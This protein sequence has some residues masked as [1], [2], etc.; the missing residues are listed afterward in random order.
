MTA[1]VFDPQSISGGSIAEDGT[2]LIVNEPI[3]VSIKK[4]D[5]NGNALSGAVLQIVKLEDG[6]DEEIVT[7]WSSRNDAMV[8]S[9]GL[10][11]GVRYILREQGSLTGYKTAADVAFKL[12]AD[13]TIDPDPDKTTA[14][15]K[16][17]VILFRN[18]PTSVSIKRVDS[19]GAVL[20]GAVLQILDKNNN[21]V[22]EWTSADDAAVIT[23]ILVVEES[24]TLHEKTPIAAYKKADD[25]TIQLDWNGAI[26]TAVE[27]DSD[28]VILFRNQPAY[29]VQVISR[30][31]M[32]KTNESGAAEQTVAKGTAITDVV[33]TAD[34]G[35]YFP[36]DYTVETVNGISVTRKNDSQIIVSGK[37]TNN[38]VITLKNPTRVQ[39]IIKEPQG[40]EY[41]KY[42]ENV[43]QK[44]LKEPGE[45]EN[46][47]ILYRVRVKGD[48][49]FS[50]EVP[51]RI[52]PGSYTVEWYV[53]G[54]ENY[55]DLG[56]P[57][58]PHGSI[59]V[60]ITEMED[61]IADIY[62]V[63]RNGSH[64]IPYGVKD[65]TLSFTIRVMN[66]DQMVAEAKNVSLKVSSGDSKVEIPVVFNGKVTGQ[67]YTVSLVGL[68]AEVRGGVPG[69][70]GPAFRLS[71]KAWITDKVTIYLTWDDGQ[72][73]SEP[74]KLRI[75]AL[76]EDEIGAYRLL[77]DG[78]KEYLIF[79]TYDI[80][81]AW[82]GSDELCSGYEHC[83]HKS[84]PY[85]NPFAKGGYIGEIIV[86]SN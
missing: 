40:P 49:E 5:E 31:N 38:A 11:A 74:Q 61:V 21:V 48:E 24:Y 42:S 71:Y 19:D 8:I 47:T 81:M 50:T 85:E 79:N 30:S 53:K 65:L 37:P 80:C 12:K 70:E 17:D 43:P 25:I 4:V 63:Q 26:G 67:G 64:G 73:N 68:P 55:G 13:G 84:S 75:Y 16:N 54:N 15:V 45:A 41:L 58:N 1:G 66:G 39:K 83:F 44:L 62:N 10:T 78:T 77:D 2:I 76:P 32:T 27:I 14:E 60:Q 46:G 35:Y 56:S 52:G 72:V 59:I 29:T 57:K 82:L 34:E 20:S 28:G 18:E 69:A 51:E 9:S 3:S 7:G 22:S 36:E 23:G 33:Y 6:G 86:D